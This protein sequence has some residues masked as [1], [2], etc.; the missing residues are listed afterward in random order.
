M[1]GAGLVAAVLAGACGTPAP[2]FKDADNGGP[3]DH[4]WFQAGM[5]WRGDQCR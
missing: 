2:P 5:V 3:N 4:G 1:L